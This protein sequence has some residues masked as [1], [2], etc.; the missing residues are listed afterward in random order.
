MAF[1]DNKI[2]VADLTGKGVTG[3]A[4]TPNLTTAQM[5]QKLDEIAKEVIPPKF[6][7][8]CDDLDATDFSSIITS[9]S[10]DKMLFQRLNEYDQIE[11]SVDNVNWFLVASGKEVLDPT[12]EADNSKKLGG[13]LPAYYQKTTDSA[14]NTTDKT[15][16]GAINEVK[17]ALDNLSSDAVDINYD[18]TTSGLTA[19][20]VQSAID[21]VNNS[22]G[23]ISTISGG[24]TDSITEFLK[25]WIDNNLL[26]DPNLLELV[27]AMTS[28]T[29]PSGITSA[30]A[31]YEPGYESYKAFD[32]NISTRWLSAS[33]TVAY[34]Q[35]EF[36]TSKTVKSISYQLRSDS[37]TQD[38]DTITISFKIDDTWVSNKTI[39]V[40]KDG[41]VHK[42]DLDA[43]VSNV[44]GIKYTFNVATAKNI[45]LVEL[46]A[47][48]N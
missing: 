11:Y 34:L 39:T 14:L 21:E 6:N 29:T 3:M 9:K 30:S 12:L 23:D 16:T 19:T 25:Y 32:R 7:A 47:Y 43:V 35:Y 24:N 41:S 42:V 5:Q 8:L 26:P 13:Q 28:D 22:L 4:D 17:N 45:S 18:N 46:Q 37:R 20:N 38:P 27:P 33:G 2:T 36:A 44:T 10:T 15:T 1:S 48:G 31:V 40:I